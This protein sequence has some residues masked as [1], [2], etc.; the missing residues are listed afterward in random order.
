MEASEQ[1]M[2]NLRHV[3]EGSLWI[4]VRA[5]LVPDDVLCMPTTARKWNVRTPFPPHEIR[6]EVR[7]WALCRQ[8]DHEIRS[9]S[10]AWI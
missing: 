6:V 10:T 5:F 7:A 2:E 3:L 1:V 9:Q 4:T 8:T